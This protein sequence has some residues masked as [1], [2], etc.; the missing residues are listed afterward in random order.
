[1]RLVTFELV[2]VGNFG[3]F[4]ARRRRGENAVSAAR[5]RLQPPRRFVRQFTMA[6]GRGRARL[7]TFEL[8]SVG[9]FGV[10]ALAE[11]AGRT[12]SQPLV[13]VCNL[14]GASFDSSRLRLDEG[15]RDSLRSNS[16]R[17]ET[18]GLSALA[19]DAGRTPSQ[20][21]VPVCNLRGASFDS[22]RLRL[23]EGRARAR[24]TR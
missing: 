6:S 8:V 24:R 7:V 21:L 3:V 23:D 2:S 1:M 14:R 10:F 12:P 15:A 9:N 16:F 18:S 4:G 22:S 20:P 13:P 11:D 19:E 5:A 17:S